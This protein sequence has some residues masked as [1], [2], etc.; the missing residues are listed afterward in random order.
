M[1]ILI[2]TDGGDEHGMGHVYQSMTLAG[3]L[4]DERKNV[5]IEFATKSDNYIVDKLME[6]G[7]KVEKLGN[8]EDIFLKIKN[9]K[10]EKVIFDKIDVSK[11]LVIKIKK[12]TNSKVI[13]FT[14]M[15]DANDYA[16]ISVLADIGSD[17]K[18]LTMVN[19][20]TGSIK[21]FGPKY[22]ILRPEFYIDNVIRGRRLLS[23]KNILLI[24]G[25]SDP[26]NLSYHVL[27]ELLNIY[28]DI[29]VTLIVGSGVKCEAE[30]YE[31]LDYYDRADKVLVIKNAS[32]VAEIMKNQDVVF[33]SPGL[34]FFEALVLGVPV[35]GFHQNS[36]QK[37]TYKEYL[38]T[39]DIL[40]L[41]KLKEIIENKKF[42]FPNDDF[43][44]EMEI[45]MGKKLLI[46][47]I[48]VG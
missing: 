8:D 4:L 9:E 14:N 48:L 22:W 23:V 34:S 18:N 30:V 29:N 42:I 19:E 32:N 37:E 46:N 35:L 3:Y 6:S 15:T 43:I 1:K 40:E 5:N 20:D 28:V 36:L 2:V 44:S 38:P 10:F 16:D 17:F 11:D 33:A 41:Y 45:G 31:L 25:G 27:K 12:R 24:F 47:N 21:Y 26:L 7:L 13:I 39:V